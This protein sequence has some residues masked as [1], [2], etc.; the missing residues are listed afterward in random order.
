MIVEW[1]VHPGLDDIVNDDDDVESLL[2]VSIQFFPG[3]FNILLGL[4]EEVNVKSE[5]SSIVDSLL[6][7]INN[8]T[9]NYQ[10]ITNKKYREIILDYWR[11][12]S[13]YLLKVSNDEIRVNKNWD[14]GYQLSYRRNVIVYLIE[15]I[16][17]FPIQ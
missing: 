3:L 12:F 1:L 15:R 8:V 14:R 4:N 11:F 17:T 7:A 2:R 9:E 10:K 6:Q 13:G 5:V 16:E